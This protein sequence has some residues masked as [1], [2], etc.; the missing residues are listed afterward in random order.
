MKYFDNLK[1]FLPPFIHL[2]QWSLALTINC[3]K[4]FNINEFLVP[5]YKETIHDHTHLQELLSGKHAFLFWFTQFIGLLLPIALL[6][7]KKIR[8]SIP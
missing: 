5:G 1:I 7:F 2:I 4:N 3:H 8:K 6:V